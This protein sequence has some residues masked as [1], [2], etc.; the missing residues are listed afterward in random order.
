M[1]DERG[2]HDVSRLVVRQ[3][4]RSAAVRR[5]RRL[6][7]GCVDLDEHRVAGVRDEDQQLLPGLRDRRRD[8]RHVGLVHQ[9]VELEV[10]SWRQHHLLRE[11]PEL[12]HLRK[13]WRGADG[14]GGASGA[15]GAVGRLP[16][17]AIVR[18]IVKPR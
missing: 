15:G 9:W 16:R 10:V 3:P 13:E 8:D 2:R 17:R 6:C 1:A 12:L 14:T 18:L 5:R 7:G 11:L 4:W